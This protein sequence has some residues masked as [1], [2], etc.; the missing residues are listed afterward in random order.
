[1]AAL[2]PKHHRQYVDVV[3]EPD[4]VWQLKPLHHWPRHHRDGTISDLYLTQ[5]V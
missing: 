1:M 5:L 2:P 3:A 4:E